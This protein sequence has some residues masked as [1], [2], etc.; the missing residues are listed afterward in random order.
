M[1]FCLSV[2]G[3]KQMWKK[4]LPAIFMIGALL[5]LV[6]I[7]LAADQ[8]GD[9]S[10]PTQNQACAIDLM[11]VLDSSPSISDP[12]YGVM[13]EWVLEL[14]GRFTIG[15]DDARIG[16]VQFA[17]HAQLEVGLWEHRAELEYAVINMQRF[18][19]S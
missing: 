12:D 17:G 16:V 5:A 10:N 14:I 7:G 3:I 19:D 9:S 2:S 18:T 11:L 8:N 4:I 13:K 6:S 1:R 15:A